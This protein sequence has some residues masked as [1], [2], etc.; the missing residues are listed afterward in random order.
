MKLALGFH[1]DLDNPEPAEE[2]MRRKAEAWAAAEPNVTEMHILSV[3][4]HPAW[5]TWYAVEVELLFRDRP[6]QQSLWN[7]T[8]DAA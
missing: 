3:E 8:G 2:Q 1:V 4:R 5:R 7:V 6:E